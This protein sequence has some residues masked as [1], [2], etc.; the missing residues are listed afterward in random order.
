[1]GKSE[2]ANS[3][4]I[5]III[6]LFFS[7]IVLMLNS[8]L[9]T[10]VLNNPDNPVFLNLESMQ[11][12]QNIDIINL[13]NDYNLINN[14]I[15][16]FIICM[17][18]AFY[19][20]ILNISKYY[21]KISYLFLSVGCLSIILSSLIC[22]LFISLNLKIVNFNEFL[23]AYFVIEPIRYSYI[24]F[25]MLIVIILSSILY[26]ITI[27][28]LLFKRFQDFKL[29]KQKLTIE[30]TFKKPI[31]QININLDKKK[32]SNVDFY[33]KRKNEIN[34]NWF[35]NDL[36]KIKLNE[37]LDSSFIKKEKKDVQLNSKKKIKHPIDKKTPFSNA[38]KKE[39]IKH[40]QDE[41]NE[42][43]VSESLE[44]ALFSAVDKIKKRKSNS[45]KNKEE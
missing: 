34:S 1:M 31:E 5:I 22:Y 38:F 8:F 29:K 19:G 40:I 45:G 39:K 44:K 24:K 42:V 36:N 17:F 13:Y 6:M 37:E 27:L 2:F 3:I 15:W 18:I 23:L 16:I 4:E 20:V 41:K 14:F 28:P 32:D 26:N 43:E 11:Y 9:P 21:T 25:I 12:N 35:S 7:I 10:V 33:F 30:K